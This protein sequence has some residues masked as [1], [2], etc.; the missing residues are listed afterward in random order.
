MPKSVLGA[1]ASMSPPNA[2]ML[3]EHTRIE[4]LPQLIN[5]LRGEMQLADTYLFD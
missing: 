1:T 2:K 3:L 5:V 4:H